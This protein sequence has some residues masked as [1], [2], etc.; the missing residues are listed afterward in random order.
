MPTFGTQWGLHSCR[1]PEQR[2]GSSAFIARASWLTAVAAEVCRSHPATSIT[3]SSALTMASSRTSAFR[4]QET[5]LTR[6]KFKSGFTRVPLEEGEQTTV[7]GIVRD[8]Q[9]VTLHLVIG[10]AEG[11]TYVVDNL[12]VRKE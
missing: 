5:M 6:G 9:S 8:D 11:G 12:H 1:N 7:T 2:T 10:F 3:W 4:W